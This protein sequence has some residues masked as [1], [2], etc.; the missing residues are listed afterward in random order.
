MVLMMWDEDFNILKV[1]SAESEYKVLIFHSKIVVRQ[2]VGTAQK[3]RPRKE[4]ELNWN[5]FIQ[6]RKGLYRGSQIMVLPKHLRYS[7]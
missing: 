1:I 4:V 6:T 5:D 2:Y 3:N 7:W